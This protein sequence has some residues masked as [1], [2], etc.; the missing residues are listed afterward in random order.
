MGRDM[1]IHDPLLDYMY[2]SQQ[3]SNIHGKYM[4]W[5]SYSLWIFRPAVRCRFK[6]HRFAA[7]YVYTSLK[8]GAETKPWDVSST[9][10]SR[11]ALICELHQKNKEHLLLA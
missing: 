6:K 7:I 3:K 4:Q 8:R 11:E 9:C 10:A 5:M 2:T 1:V